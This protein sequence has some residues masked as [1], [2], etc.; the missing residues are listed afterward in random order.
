MP[1]AARRHYTAEFKV[2]VLREADACSKPGEIGAL[3][4]REGIY[5]SLLTTWRRERE[6][7]ELDALTPKKR[8]RKANDPRDAENERLRRENEKL[9]DRL[10]KAELL[11]VAVVPGF[12]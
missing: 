10:G 9:Q 4:R 8:G 7:G 6:R 12:C 2:R 3:L 5:S 11:S 1:K